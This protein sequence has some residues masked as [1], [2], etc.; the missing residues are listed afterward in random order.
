MTAE[1]TQAKDL[2]DLPG[3]FIFKVFAKPDLFS[4]AN[5]L[6]TAATVLKQANPQHTLRKNQ[7][8]KGTYEAYTLELQIEV[9]EQIEALYQAFKQQQGVVMVL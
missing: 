7:S 4:E 6:K 8:R 5:L 3:P 1:K 2:I 9:Y